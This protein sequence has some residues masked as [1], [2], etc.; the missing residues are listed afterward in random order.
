[1]RATACL[2][3]GDPA[4]CRQLCI[5][6]LE[7]SPRMKPGAQSELLRALADSYACSGDKKREKMARKACAP[8]GGGGPKD[9]W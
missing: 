4:A 1:V 7:S 6:A 9:V 5:S 2:T 3:G 8:G